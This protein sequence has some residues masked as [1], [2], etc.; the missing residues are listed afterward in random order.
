MFL[1]FSGG[2]DGGV[3]VSDS[4][5]SFVTGAEPLSLSPWAFTSSYAKHVLLSSNSGTV[6]AGVTRFFFISA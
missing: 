4:G 1:S 5:H 6:Y 3:S 2:G